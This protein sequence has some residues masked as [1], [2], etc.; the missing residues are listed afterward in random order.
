MVLIIQQIF[1]ER[2]KF[3]HLV[4]LKLL[5]HA[6]RSYILN[7]FSN[8]LLNPNRNILVDEVFH[9]FDL[10]LFLVNI[11]VDFIEWCLYLGPLL[12]EIALFLLLYF[13]LIDLDCQ[14]LNFLYSS[15]SSLL[16][17]FIYLH[18]C[19]KFLLY[20]FECGIDFILAI[21]DILDHFS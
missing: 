13:K 12:L 21:T 6:M 20:D 7:S 17:H 14:L 3:F 1:I 10:I 19:V 4:I 16:D 9:N 5:F 8:L 2:L 15:C 18:Y 11:L